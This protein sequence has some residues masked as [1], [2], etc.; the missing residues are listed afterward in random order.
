MFTVQTWT[1]RTPGTLS[2]NQCRPAKAGGLKHIL[3]AY[4]QVTTVVDGKA[5]QVSF[6]GGDGEILPT[7]LV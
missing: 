4:H 6:L 7:F 1:L 3:T 5:E 2:A